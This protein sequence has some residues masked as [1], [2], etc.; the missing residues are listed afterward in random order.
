MITFL[1]SWLVL[2]MLVIGSSSLA[3]EKMRIQIWHQMIYS[4]RQVLTEAIQNFE[5]ENPDITIQA[6]YR[7]TEEL[8][9]SYQAAAMGGSGPELVFGPSDQIGPFATMGIIR[10]LNEVYKS[11][12]FAQYDSLATPLYKGYNYMIG[13]MAGNHL[14]LIY[15]KKLVSAPPKSSAELI[16][17]GKKLTIDENGDGKIDRYGLVFNYTEPFF[18]APFIPAFGEPFMKN[19]IEPQLNTEAVRKTFQYI[20]DLRDKHKVIP[21]ECD[22]ET[23]NALF[24]QG[25]AAMIINGDWSW[26][27]YKE[28]KMD[29]GITAIPMISETERWPSPL[30]GTAGY[31]LNVNVT[32]PERLAATLKV[33]NYLTSEKTQLLFTERV[34]TLPSLLSLREHP[35]V[36]TNPLLQMS[37]EIM[38]IGT[39]MP[40]VPEIRAVWDSLRVQYQKILANSITPAEAAAQAQITAE[41]QIKDMNDV[42]KPDATLWVIQLIALLGVLWMVWVFRGAAVAF[43]KGFWGPQRFVYFMML[44]AFLGIFAVVI[45]PFF[46]NIAISLSN[47]GL[48][49]FQDWSLI[50]LHHYV[51]SL[52]DPKFYSLFLKTLIWTLANVFFHVTI[53]VFLAVIINQVLPAKAFWRTLFIIPWAVPQYITA[54]TWRGMFN[55]EYGPIN[56]FLQ[57]YL[58]LSPVQWLSQPFTAFA[59]C[60]VTNVWLGFPF[61]MIVALG[62]L[63]SIPH[64]LYEAAYLDKANA[65]QRFRHIT[66][67]LLMPVMVPAALLGCIWTFNNLNIVW[68]VS[69]AGEPGDQ[70]HILVSYVY[71]AAF[72][73]YRYGYAA[74]VS[75]LIFLILIVWSLSSLRAQFKKEQKS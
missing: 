7:E 35:I 28:I 56:L 12:H 32:D 13:S 34:G 47:F 53:G 52:T 71:K 33:L 49:T 68:L 17:M 50:G 37:S 18:I 67:P 31:S 74:S 4:H 9:S 72:N 55:Q 38:K 54:L 69:N 16:E 66:L 1:K 2:A 23:A 39:P 44:P 20:L 6:T 70:T 22:Y 10:P 15:N 42:V 30:V 59:A 63:Q 36:K 25:K 60:I 3:A 41:A 29:F 14:T 64:S 26:G 65:W 61:M 27:D 21:K 45:Y 51:V 57:Q 75:M 11:E 24:K 5:K 58:H 46:Y 73:L 43:V 40:V 19:G 48:R 8:R 62:G